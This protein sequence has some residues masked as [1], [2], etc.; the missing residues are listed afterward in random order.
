LKKK[1]QRFVNREISWL[2]FNDRVMQEAADP[3]VPLIERLKFLG[4]YSS[5]LDEF[6]SVRVGTLH[7]LVAAKLKAR[8]FLGGTPK[9]VLKAIHQIVVA[10]RDKFDTIFKGLQAEL[11]RAHIHIVDERELDPAQ[12]KWVQSYFEREVRPRL[13]PI[14]LDSLPTFPYL[15]N[16]VIYLAVRLCRRADPDSVR[17]ALI[18]VPTGVLPR[19]VTLPRQGQRQTIIMLDDVIRFG[20]KDIF[21]IFDC[22]TFGA[23][24][25][26]L[27]RDAEIDI[28]DDV[29]K[30]F[31]EKISASIKQ[32]EFGQPVRFVYDREIPEDLL[33][34]ILKRSDLKRF[35]NLIEGGR[36][37]NAKDF[38]SFPSVGPAG[39]AHKP[40]PALLHPDLARRRSLFAAIREKDILLHFP[41]QSFDHIIDLLREA[42]IDPQVQSIKMTLYR[43]APHSNVIN[44]LLNALR[45]GKQVA[46]VIELRARFD[47]EANIH[48]TRKLE[49]EGAQIIEG[50]PGLKIHAKLCLITR[51]EDDQLVHYANLATGNFNESTARI[52]SD[53]SLLTANRALTREVVKLFKF[54]EKNYKTAK[55]KQLIL[56]PFQTRMR[57]SKLLANEVKNARRGKPAYLLAKMNSLVDREMIEKL[58]AA[59][60]AGVKI[61]MV[62]RGICAL[63]P[64]IK[65]LSENIEVVSIVDRYLEHS[66]IFIFC[67]GGEERT[68]ISSADWMIRNLDNRVEVTAPIVDPDIQRELRQFMQ[69]QFADN[70]KTRLINAA[71]DNP[72]RARAGHKARSAQQDT[73]DLLK[74]S[75]PPRGR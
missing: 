51:I 8:E 50:V 7:R 42:A 31:F 25:I 36:Y 61:R 30:S 23:Y 38:M 52:Y 35:D 40:R 57:M 56:S 39:L 2:A 15:K 45:N 5:N 64:G 13:V 55:Y 21:A 71:Q 68:Y 66:R 1:A 53:H 75:R 74:L 54:F 26:K 28:D 49:E 24:T 19:F 58:Y 3:S 73:Y 48:W 14:M 4:I 10:Q 29:T 27:T 6:F 22:D 60:Q 20:L 41:Y 69:I 16:V 18:E 37:H 32:R 70:T 67:N 63:I 59:S 47:E 11:K 43:L 65:G 62:V 33:H 34:F 72:Y 12:Q 17:Y 46:V 9:Q 44:A